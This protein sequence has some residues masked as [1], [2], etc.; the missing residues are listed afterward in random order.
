MERPKVALM[1]S[2]ANT[3]FL[4]VFIQSDEILLGNLCINKPVKSIFFPPFF[5]S[6]RDTVCLCLSFCLYLHLV[7]ALNTEHRAGYPDA[8]KMAFTEPSYPVLLS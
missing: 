1:Q 6:N 8:L 3:L 4:S 2:H 5:G 7:F